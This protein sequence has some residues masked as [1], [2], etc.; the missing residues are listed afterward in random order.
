MPNPK[1]KSY[2]ITIT[3]PPNAACV[4]R[5]PSLGNLAETYASN[6]EDIIRERS[7][8]KCERPAYK[9]HTI[10]LSYKKLVSFKTDR[11]ASKLAGWLALKP[12]GGCK[13]A[14][15]NNIRSPNNFQ[16]I[17]EYVLTKSVFTRNTLHTNNFQELCHLKM[18]NQ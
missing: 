16:S 3:F 10:H 6:R 8:K 15:N 4:L 11:Q 12:S 7:G 14:L 17:N 9:F 13:L 18:L 5:F 2:L 1:Y